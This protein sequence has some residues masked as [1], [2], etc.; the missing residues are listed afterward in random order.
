MEK[1]THA[2]VTEVRCSCGYLER[3]ADHPQSPIVFDVELNEF[4]IEYPDP[5]DPDSINKAT[6]R[7]YHCPFCGGVAPESKRGQ[8]FAH[9]AFDEEQRICE[10]VR[11][12][13]TLDEAIEKFGPPDDDNPSGLLESH[14]AADGRGPSRER[15]RTLTYANLS[16]SAEVCLAD[17]R[18]GAVK[19]ILHGKYLGKP[20]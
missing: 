16:E 12:I 4:N 11:G 17:S 6:L 19:L 1:P 8:L 7:I 5:D 14:P 13:R 2:S 10:L 3:A 18:T 9:L 20:S 15:F